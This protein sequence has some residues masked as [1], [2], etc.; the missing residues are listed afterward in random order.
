MSKS[1]FFDAKTVLFREGD[2]ANNLMIIKNGQA[3]CL[4][5]SKERLIPVFLAKE[6]D[7][8]GES[9]M[10]SGA[11][12]T[13]SVIALSRIEVI[14]IPTN[15][16]RDALGTAP[17]WLT[18]LTSTMVLRFQNTAALIAENRALH[19]SILSEEEFTPS[20]EIEYKK[21]LS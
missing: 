19:P 18:D 20:L 2:E 14:L 21:L 10:L 16:F 13:Y 12:Y 3:I 6:Q 9:A 8:I 11:P 1:T 7:I 17:E 4:K 5:A 15:T